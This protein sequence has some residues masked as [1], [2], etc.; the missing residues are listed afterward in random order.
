[1]KDGHIMSALELKFAYSFKEIEDLR[2]D[3]GM[4]K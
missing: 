2:E 3:N 4:L 1:M